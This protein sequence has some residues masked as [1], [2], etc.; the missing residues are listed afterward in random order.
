MVLEVALLVAAAALGVGSA[1]QAGET[2]ELMSWDRRRGMVGVSGVLCRPRG[3]GEFFFGA[4]DGQE[5]QAC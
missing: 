5:P 3:L 1:S 2:D 4:A